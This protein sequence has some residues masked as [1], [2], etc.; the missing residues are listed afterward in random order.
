MPLVGIVV[1]GIFFGSVRAQQ[2]PTPPSAV[3]DTYC[4]TCHNDKART[5]GLS[6]EHADLVDLP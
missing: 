6:L 1:A 2:K 5:G 4:V 3:I